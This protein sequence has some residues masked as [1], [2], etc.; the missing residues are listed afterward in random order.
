MPARPTEELMQ[1]IYASKPAIHAKHRALPLPEKV[2][3]VIELQRI[4]Y[5]MRL[6][7]GETP[8]WWQRPWES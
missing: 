3:Q 1:S 5:E 6:Q 7:R 4:D 8:E 2:R